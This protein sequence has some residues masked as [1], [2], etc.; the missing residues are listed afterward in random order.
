MSQPSA[1]YIDGGIAGDERPTLVA[2]FCI[3]RLYKKM[4]VD[5][6]RSRVEST[7]KQLH[8]YQLIVEQCDKHAHYAELMRAELDL[9]REMV[10]LLP[11][12]IQ[13]LTSRE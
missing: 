1:A 7:R 5:T 4:I 12:K 13:M 3:A 2:W 6:D 11:R 8:Y 9:C 10:E